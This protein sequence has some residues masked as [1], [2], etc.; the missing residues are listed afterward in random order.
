[1]R[2][3]IC[4]M[5]N[6]LTE[7][8]QKLSKRMARYITKI[9]TKAE[10]AVIGGSNL[11]H[12]KE[13]VLDQLNVPVHV[14]ANSGTKYYKYNGKTLEKVYE[15]ELEDKD[16]ILKAIDELM[17]EYKIKP[18][19]EQI[20]DRGSQITLSCL[21]R[22]APQK[23]KEAY[24]KNKK[25]RK[26]FVNY[27]KKKLKGFE[28]TI[29]GTTSID[30]TKKGM[31]KGFGIKEFIRINN[32][33]KEDCLFIGDGL[34]KGGNDYSVAG[35]VQVQKVDSPKDTE[36]IFKEV[37]TWTHSYSVVDKE[38]ECPKISPKH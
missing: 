24:D 8:C 18:E 16:K 25:K 10:F 15:I 28:I 26:K 3:L 1:M 19:S 20:Q 9:T 12:I 32:F 34:F 38:K 30:I 22:N 21:G 35:V 36:K 6:T 7:S 2:I 33:D 29:G 14:L 23:D 5:D 4:D 17:N 13:Q 11:S 37:L 27:L 31:N